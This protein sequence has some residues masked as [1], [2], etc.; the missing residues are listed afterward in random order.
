MIYTALETAKAN[1]LNPE[2]YLNRLL[3]VLPERFFRQSLDFPTSPRR[4]EA[5]ADKMQALFAML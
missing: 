3:P 4:S 5:W 2:A 1:G